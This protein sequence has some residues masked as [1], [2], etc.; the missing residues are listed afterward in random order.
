MIIGRIMRIPNVK[1]DTNKNV[2]ESLLVGKQKQ[3]CVTLYAK[4]IEIL[5]LSNQQTNISKYRYL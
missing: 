1:N 4:Q 2:R 5:S 3:S